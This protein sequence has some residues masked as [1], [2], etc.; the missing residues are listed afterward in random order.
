MIWITLEQWRQVLK[1]LHNPT[2][3]RWYILVVMVIIIMAIGD[4]IRRGCL[5]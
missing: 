2:T 3:R 5:W 4:Y 1:S